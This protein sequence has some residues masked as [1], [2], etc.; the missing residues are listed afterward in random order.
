MQ[1]LST[2]AFIFIAITSMVNLILR[3]WR[4]NAV[5]LAVQYLAAFYLIT[6]SWPVGLSVIK[7]I[8]GWMATA[9][10]ALT[11]LRQRKD[12]PPSEP[13]ASLVFRGLAGIIVILVI[14]VLAPGLQESIL[15]DIE[16]VIVQGGL[17]LMGMSLMQ[18][19]TSADPYLN[20]IS[21]L[22]L[23]AGFDVIYAALERSTLLTGLLVVLNL[24][25][26]LAGVYFISQSS[27]EKGS[28]NQ[29]P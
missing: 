18:V 10:I 3:E 6:L 26:A 9:A 8:V 1:T 14:F 27:T 28:E 13:T 2:V 16:L 7:L 24:G 29:S 17:M 25:L 21:L 20:I 5:A 23:L 19:G 15:P 4:I 12:A 11:S 22:S